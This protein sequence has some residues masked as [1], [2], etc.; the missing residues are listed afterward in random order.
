MSVAPEYF[1]ANASPSTCDIMRSRER[2]KHRGRKTL[3]F[4]FL[5]SPQCYR[6]YSILGLIGKA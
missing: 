4:V 2:A 1:Y 6:P 3:V 5:L